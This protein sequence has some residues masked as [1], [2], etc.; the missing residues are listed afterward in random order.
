[1]KSGRDINIRSIHMSRMVEVK[2]MEKSGGHSSLATSIPVFSTSMRLQFNL[3]LRSTSYN[4]Q[5]YADGPPFVSSPVFPLLSALFSFLG[6]IICLP[7]SPDSGLDWNKF[8]ET[9]FAGV[10]GCSTDFGA[11]IGGSGAVRGN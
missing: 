9:G 5:T 2:Y 4:I 11:E 10:G 7:L 3:P 8:C 6:L 1:M